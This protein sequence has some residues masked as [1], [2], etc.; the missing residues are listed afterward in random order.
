MRLFPARKSTDARRAACRNEQQELT[1][2][3]DGPD[4]AHR[5]ELEIMLE[6]ARA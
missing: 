5:R 1:A 3:L 6:D 2:I 4:T